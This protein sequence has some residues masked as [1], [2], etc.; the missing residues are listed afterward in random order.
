MHNY[1]KMWNKQ[2]VIN[3]CQILP[4][5]K[6]SRTQVCKMTPFSWF[7]EF[8]PPIEKIP[9]FAKMGRSVVYVLVGRESRTKPLWQK[10]LFKESSCDYQHNP[11]LATAFSL[12][13]RL[14]SFL[15]LK[16]TSGLEKENESAL[17]L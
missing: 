16:Y 3:T 17:E 15:F 8:A 14:A 6:I 13:M 5:F 12:W 1:S 10:M 7:H 9:F 11:N 4:F 2:M